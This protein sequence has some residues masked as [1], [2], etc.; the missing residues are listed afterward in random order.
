[1]GDF[2]LINRIILN[3]LKDTR[4]A[5]RAC[6]PHGL[7]VKGIVSAGSDPNISSANRCSSV[8]LNLARHFKEM[9]EGSFTRFGIRKPY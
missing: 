8:D 3:F 2:P 7:Q 6:C 4:E 5:K 1:M 9:H